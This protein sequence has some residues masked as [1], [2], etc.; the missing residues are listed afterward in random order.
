MDACV[1]HVSVTLWM[2]LGISGTCIQRE[3]VLDDFLISAS[4]PNPNRF[5]SEPNLKKSSPLL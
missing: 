2:G 3:C 1:P 5:N 4:F